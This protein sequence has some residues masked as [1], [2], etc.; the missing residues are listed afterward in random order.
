MA[1]HKKLAYLIFLLALAGGVVAWFNSPFPTVRP[2]THVIHA[3]VLEQPL[4]TADWKTY[5]NEEMGFEIKIPP[6]W[7]K[8]Y[9]I[10]EKETTGK[11][12]G[13][14]A[15]LKPAEWIN[16]YTKEKIPH[17]YMLFAITVVSQEW[18]EKEL[19][20]DQPHPGIIQR[21][22]DRAHVYVV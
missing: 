1:S 16:A 19:S 21:V 13:S 6:R 20:Y 10:E 18:L 15:F 8:D 14:V 2:I 9:K 7:E 22:N 12:F 11:G 17:D 4:D 3:P 5:R